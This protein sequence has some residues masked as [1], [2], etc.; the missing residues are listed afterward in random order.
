MPSVLRRRRNQ[1]DEEVVMVELKQLR[2]RQRIRKALLLIWLLLLAI[3][4][5]Y[6]PPAMIIEGAAVGVVAGSFIAFG[7]MFLSAIFVGRLW[8]GWAC[9]AD[10]LQEFGSPI[11][12]GRAPRRRLQWIK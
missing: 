1:S 3:T 4:L 7:L 9:P 12:N 6:F 2:T 10:A 11:N 5:N 8:C